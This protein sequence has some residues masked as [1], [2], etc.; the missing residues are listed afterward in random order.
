M[1]HRPAGRR[2]AAWPAAQPTR[3]RTI[4]LIGA[5]DGE[6]AVT[7]QQDGFAGQG[8]AQAVAQR[9]AT[10]CDVAFHQLALVV[11]ARPNARKESVREWDD[12]DRG[13]KGRKRGHGGADAEVGMPRSSRKPGAGALRFLLSNDDAVSAAA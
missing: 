12:P 3:N 10:A 2:G 8:G 7:G 5:G 13:R 1:R 11:N 4:F 9:F 6:R